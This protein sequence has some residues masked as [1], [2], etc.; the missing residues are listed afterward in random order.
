MSL[1]V[2]GISGSPAIT[3]L[4]GP[5]G[6]RFVMYGGRFVIYGGRFVILRWKI[7]A[8]GG[9]FV[10]YGGIFVIFFH[11]LLTSL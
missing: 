11:F 8:I 7:H 5:Y 9:R 10:I 1:Y 6:G 4:A 3:E 2:F